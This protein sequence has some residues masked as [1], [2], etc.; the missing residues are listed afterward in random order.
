VT[1][2]NGKT[3]EILVASVAPAI[4]AHRLEGPV[5][6]ICF[7]DGDVCGGDACCGGGDIFFAE[8]GG[9]VHLATLRPIVLAG[10][11]VVDREIWRFGLAV[12][13]DAFKGSSARLLDD[14][15]L[16]EL[17]LF[18]AV[19]SGHVDFVRSRNRKGGKTT[20]THG[21]SHW[22]EAVAALALAR[23]ESTRADNLFDELQELAATAETESYPFRFHS[24][25]SPWEI[26]LRPAIREIV[27]DVTAGTDP[28][29]IVGRFVNAIAR[30]TASAVHEFLDGDEVAPIVLTGDA[31][32]MAL[33]AERLQ[34]KLAD[35]PW[36]AE[37]PAIYAGGDCCP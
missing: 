6:G 20:S 5:L 35:R 11:G 18:K 13:E 12:V 17:D 15:I 26:D 7:G 36:S 10:G 16:K 24:G 2:V 19:P 25:E 28:G 8:D 3:A 27:A 9:A 4:S 29:R 30:S 22:L 33:L 14:G 37:P 31:F 21:A 34:A 23:P 1:E 32:R